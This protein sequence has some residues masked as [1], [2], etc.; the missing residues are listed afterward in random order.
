MVNDKGASKA[1]SMNTMVALECIVQN[2]NFKTSWIN[3]SKVSLLKTARDRIPQIHVVG[4]NSASSPGIPGMLQFRDLRYLERL[5]LSRTSPVVQDP[6][7]LLTSSSRHVTTSLL[8][9]P[10]EPIATSKHYQILVRRHSVLIQLAP[11]AALLLHDRC[12]IFATSQGDEVSSEVARSIADVIETSPEGENMSFPLKCLEGIFDYV[13]K[14]LDDNFLEQEPE[15]RNTISSVLQTNQGVTLERL[16]QIQVKTEHQ[17]AQLIGYQGAFEELLSSDMEMALLDLEKLQKNPELYMPQD[18]LK[19]QYF[20][21]EAEFMIENYA[22][23]IDGTHARISGIKN[24]I[25]NA[26]Q[27]IMLKLGTAR[28]NLL[29]YQ[30][31]VDAVLAVAM[32][33]AL[34]AGLFG[35]NLQEESPFKTQP[36]IFWPVWVTMITVVPVALV[37]LKSWLRGSGMLVI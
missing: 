20:H 27:T 23:A 1:A 2:R 18:R 37:A 36:G 25:Q 12:F 10:T 13:C 26:T 21:E 24:E 35:M 11:V 15:I 22:Q 31:L 33:S 30:I 34:V 28:N 29:F 16:R 32:T 14:S 7:G 5:D 17:I 6:R 3:I 19:W 4:V 9:E 8:R